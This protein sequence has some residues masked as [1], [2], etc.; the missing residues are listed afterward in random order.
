[1]LK[2]VASFWKSTYKKELDSITNKLSA[3]TTDDRVFNNFSE[4]KVIKSAKSYVNNEL[5]T[6]NKDE[7]K[8]K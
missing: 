2:E 8:A 6:I 7:D 3:K 5:Q 4:E 1:M